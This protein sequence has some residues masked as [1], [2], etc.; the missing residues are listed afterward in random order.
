LLLSYQALDF[1]HVG[2]TVLEFVIFGL[3]LEDVEKCMRV[4]QGRTVSRLT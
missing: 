1:V 4:V 2:G 3:A